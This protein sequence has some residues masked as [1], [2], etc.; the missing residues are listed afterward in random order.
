M[1]I[2]AEHSH[3]CYD[4]CASTTGDL[5]TAHIAKSQA[6]AQ[7]Y[8]LHWQCVSDHIMTPVQ[9]R[10]TKL[11]LNRSGLIA[12]ILRLEKFAQTNMFVDETWTTVLP[13]CYTII[14]PSLYLVAACLPS[15]RPIFTN[16]KASLSNVTFSDLSAWS[17]VAGLRGRSGTSLHSNPV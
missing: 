1:E 6:G 12:S 9:F 16:V 15:L 11:T 17:I 5:E 7:C 10:N 3:R 4:A 14:E 8:F 2:D 13:I